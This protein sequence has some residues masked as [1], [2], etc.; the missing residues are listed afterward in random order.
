MIR[1]KVKIYKIANLNKPI[2]L[3]TPEEAY[4]LPK[5]IRKQQEEIA[6]NRIINLSGSNKAEDIWNYY[7]NKYQ[8]YL[9]NI[10]L[11]I[12]YKKE[13]KEHPF[14][15]VEVKKIN[16]KYNVKH[17]I[18][19]KAINN[20]NFPLIVRHEIEHILDKVIK[21]YK[22]IPQKGYINNRLDS[23]GHHYKHPKSFESSYPHIVAIRK[24]LENNKPVSKESVD[25][26]NIPLPKDY[27]QIN[28]QYVFK[29]NISKTHNTKIYKIA[30]DIEALI[31]NISL[32]YPVANNTDNLLIRKDVPNTSS[33]SATLTNYKELPNIRNVPIS[34]FHLTGKS[35]SIQENE[36]IKQLEEQIKHNKEINPLIVVVDKEGPY[37]LEGGHRADALYNLKAKYIPA[38]VIIDLDNI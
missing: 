6:S 16:N 10:T 13:I 25:T 5:D 29:P 15:G 34:E 27:I 22:F 8:Q 28:D 35:Y 37:I 18:T 36:R 33:I 2:E 4:N 21:D 14:G 3:L 32:K 1:Q 17:Y 20:P 24:A 19:D 23:T 31:N 38:L 12:I 26:Y 30:Q 9:K 11:E 7:L